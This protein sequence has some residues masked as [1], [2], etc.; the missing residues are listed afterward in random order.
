MTTTP[1]DTLI[2]MVDFDA[3]HDHCQVHKTHQIDNR[4]LTPVRA[5]CYVTASKHKKFLKKIPEQQKK[6]DIAI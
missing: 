4:N 5:K 1:M 2:S 3:A 6:V